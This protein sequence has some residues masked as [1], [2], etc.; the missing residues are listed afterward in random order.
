MA[1]AAAASLVLQPGV[2]S[3]HEPDMAA[4]SAVRP[5][6]ATTSG[7][8]KRAYLLNAVVEA[9]RCRAHVVDRE[10]A[11]PAG[12]D[13][14]KAPVQELADPEVVEIEKSVEGDLFAFFCRTRP[15][16]RDY[17]FSFQTICIAA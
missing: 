4:A 6:A 11:H 12:E 8:R 10:I 7:G 13:I 15:S 16:R 14:P 5:V 17:R 2:L 1:V 3:Q 9:T